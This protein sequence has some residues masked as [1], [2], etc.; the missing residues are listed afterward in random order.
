MNLLAF[1]AVGFCVFSIFSV[2]NSHFFPARIDIP[3]SLAQKIQVR[4]YNA[5]SVDPIFK[6][7]RDSHLSLASSNLKKIASEMSDNPLKSKDMSISQMREF[8]QTE[9]RNRKALQT[10]LRLRKFIK[11]EIYKLIH[12]S[13]T[14]RYF[15]L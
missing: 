8:V 3:D 14:F 15:S 6:L 12:F 13:K 2:L 9:L 11:F 5:Q 1:D 7:I 10:S 4:K